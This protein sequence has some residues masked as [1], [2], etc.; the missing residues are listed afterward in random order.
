MFFETTKKRKFFSSSL[1]SHE[2]YI[3][4]KQP[5]NI[6]LFKVEPFEK[7][8][9]SNIEI[10]SPDRTKVCTILFSKTLLISTLFL[11]TSAY[12]PENVSTELSVLLA[13]SPF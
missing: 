13:T 8:N 12:L 3:S 2:G 7:S 5:S 11:M 9:S 10:A 6:C 4:T 1:F